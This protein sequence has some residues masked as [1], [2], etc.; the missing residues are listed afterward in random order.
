LLEDSFYWLLLPFII[1]HQTKPINFRRNILLKFYLKAF[2][3]LDEMHIL[4]APGIFHR[5]QSWSTA[6]MIGFKRIALA[7]FQKLG[8]VQK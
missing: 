2:F 6:V 8:F 3:V 1:L 4:F 5:I 7:G